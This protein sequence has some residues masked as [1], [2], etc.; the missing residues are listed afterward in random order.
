MLI[1]GTLMYLVQYAEASAAIPTVGTGL[2]NEEQSKIVNG[3]NSAIYVVEYVN[4]KIVGEMTDLREVIFTSKLK[5]EESKQKWKD[6]TKVWQKQ[7]K[8]QKGMMSLSTLSTALGTVGVL[9]SF[10]FALFAESEVSMLQK[11][12]KN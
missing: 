1:V 5:G 12:M 2:E 7:Q 9:A 10:A 11:Q 4:T 3:I 6:L 8:M